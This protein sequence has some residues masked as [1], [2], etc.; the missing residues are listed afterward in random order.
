MADQDPPLEPLRRI[1]PAEPDEIVELGRLEPLDPEAEE[2]P[3]AEKP[4]RSPGSQRPRDGVAV[5]VALALLLSLSSIAA[6]G[7]LVAI[8]VGGMDEAPAV[9]VAVPIDSEVA[10][11]PITVIEEAQGPTEGAGSGT[12][13]GRSRPGSDAAPAP[14]APPQPVVAPPPTAPPAPEG[15]GEGG[16]DERADLDKDK[17]TG[18]IRGPS[19]IPGW[20]DAAPGTYCDITPRSSAELVGFLPDEELSLEDADSDEDDSD[21]RGGR[22]WRDSSSETG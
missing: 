12:S 15:E 14:A 7:G 8:S 18:K 9:N 3:S 20:C 10:G 17:G 1:D 2:Q 4:T 11:P 21:S 19:R 16:A 22:H 13:D 5:A 6:I